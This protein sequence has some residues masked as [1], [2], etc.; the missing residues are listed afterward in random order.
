M[1]TSV[2]EF[3]FNKA[4][5]LQVCNFIQKRLQYRCFPVTIAIFLRIPVW[6]KV[7]ERLLL[8]KYKKRIR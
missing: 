7:C 4:A 8:F 5:V 1:E 3:L 2:P 6:K